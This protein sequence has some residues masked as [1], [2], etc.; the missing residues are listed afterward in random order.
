MSTANNWPCH[1]PDGIPVTA[2]T[3]SAVVPLVSDGRAVQA[4]D[5]MVD[6]PGP[7]DVYIKAGGADA[8]ATLTSVRV[9]AGSLQPF[10]KGPGNTHLP[11]R[12]ASGS[13]AVVIHLGDGS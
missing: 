9:P 1:G 3:A 11:L 5:V 6:N 7:L 2:N 4:Q 8:V 10:A 13:Q 12:T